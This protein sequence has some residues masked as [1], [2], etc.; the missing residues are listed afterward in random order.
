MFIY[1]S[2]EG[3][4]EYGSTA[5]TSGTSTTSESMEVDVDSKLK[6]IPLY[7]QD[8]RQYYP[9][10]LGSI[11]YLGSVLVAKD[12]TISELKEMISTLPL[13]SLLCIPSNYR[14]GNNLAL[15]G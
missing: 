2:G 15:V 1:E 11:N 6:G 8:P 5:D 3:P 7:E 4:V 12:A 14:V 10:L 9:P 13:V